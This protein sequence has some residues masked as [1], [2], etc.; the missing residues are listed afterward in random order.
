MTDY[1]GVALA[2]SNALDMNIHLMNNGVHDPAFLGEN[3]S[4]F[5]QESSAAS[6]P[7]M[8]QVRRFSWTR[9]IGLAPVATIG[10]VSL[11]EKLV[12]Q[13]VVTA[14]SVIASFLL[15]RFVVQ[16]ILRII[17]TLLRY[18]FWTAILCAGLLC[19]LGEAYF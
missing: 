1:L 17:F 3:C 6:P 9:F 7:S 15:L 14:V 2:T 19:M 8:K 16:V 18:L 10:V 11:V 4:S 5:R 13:Q 12:T